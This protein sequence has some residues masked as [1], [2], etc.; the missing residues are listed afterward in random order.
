[1]TQLSY[2]QNF[3]LSGDIE[4]VKSQMPNRSAEVYQAQKEYNLS[5]HQIMTRPEKL[6]RNTYGEVVKVLEIRLQNECGRL[7]IG[8]AFQSPFSEDMTEAIANLI[9]SVDGGLMSEQTARE[10]HPLVTDPT[11]ETLRIEKERNA[12]RIADNTLLE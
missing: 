1:M 10:L 2:L 8:H 7:K 3:I 11:A 6:V 12:K 9:N 4:A 5:T